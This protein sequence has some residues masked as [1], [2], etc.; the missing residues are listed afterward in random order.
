MFR[1]VPFCSTTIAKPSSGTIAR[2]ICI[3]EGGKSEHDFEENLRI[4][5]GA[6]SEARLSSALYVSVR[7]REEGLRRSLTLRV[8]S[9][10]R[11]R[12]VE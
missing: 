4:V 7:F 2:M 5:G 10:A 8:E 11:D 1:F 6:R 12:R 9:C 3:A